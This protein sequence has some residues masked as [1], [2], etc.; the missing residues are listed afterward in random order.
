MKIQIIGVL[1]GLL[2]AVA[3]APAADVVLET[4]S[5]RLEIGGDGIV[6]SLTSK[7]GGTEYVWPANPAPVAMVYR[8]GQPS[9]MRQEDFAENEAPDYRGGESFGATKAVLEGDK[10]T[11]RFGKANVTA[12]YRVTATRHYLALELL[13]LEGDPIDR[14]ALLQFN[15]RRL[16]YLGPWINVAC[17]D[18]FSICL[19]AGNIKTN[20]GMNRHEKYVRMRAV[21]DRAVAFEGTTAVLFGCHDPKDKFLDAMEIVERDF[22]MPSGARNRRSPIQKYSYLWCSPTPSDVDEYIKLAKRSGLRMIFFSYTSITNGAGHFTFNS[23]FPGGMDDLKKVTG[24][25]RRAGLKLGLHI[26]YSKAVKN[27]PYVTP[28]PDDRFHKVR[29]FTLAEPIDDKSVTIPVKENPA[30]CTLDKGRRILKAGKELIAYKGY[31][32]EPPL[33]FTGCER[34]HLKTTASAHRAG[35]RLGLLNVDDWDIFIRF[36]QDTDIQD[37]VARRIGKIYRQSGP[38]DMVYFDG[39]EDVHAPFWYH[40]VGAQYRVFR[41]LQP[42][43][44]VC[45]A[46]MSCHFSWHM[47]TRSNAYDVP[48][49]YIKSFT[50]KVS[51]R[52]A[53]VR[54]RDFTRMDF[55]WIFGL[56]DYIGPDALEYLLSRAAA[57][58]CPF[59]I[60]ISPKQVEANP[61]A[62]DCL[63]VIKIWEDA[64]IENKL[65]DTQRQTLKTVDPKHYEFIKTWNAMLKPERVNTWKKAKFS[66]Q[67]HHLF[68]NE[69]GQYELVAID[70]IPAWPT[71]SCSGRTA[72][73]AR[74]NQTI[75]MSSSG[76]SAAM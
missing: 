74:R 70:E 31:T 10:L 64:R 48:S 46:A 51:C 45:E 26:H 59:S 76:P 9:A 17:D 72:S 67:E 53:P 47:M 38:Y 63:D 25:I 32:T 14:I 42:E 23:K 16:P 15:I 34:G 18:R 75:L 33:R 12:T 19:C 11:V 7:P 28:V 3:P 13:K 44:P 50:H 6:K 41:Q 43:P 54:A 35:D 55:G 27:D 49:R 20:A 73:A 52:T 57:W 4:N 60:R 69:T 58:D 22:N 66:D 1:I 71:A 29:T 61:R 37:E 2:V 62:E 5:L 36:D 40:V 39:A 68:I 65:T 30:G 21:A 8:G 24:A 56:Y